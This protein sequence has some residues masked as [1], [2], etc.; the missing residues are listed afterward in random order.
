[1]GD[2]P[3]VSVTS[4]VD[5]WGRFT[6][7]ALTLAR[8]APILVMLRVSRSAPAP[9]PTDW[10]VLGPDQWTWIM[11]SAEWTT[12]GGG[13]PTPRLPAGPK[14]PA[15]SSFRLLDTF[16]S[17]KANR[18]VG[19]PASRSQYQVPLPNRRLLTRQR[20]SAMW[21][22]ALHQRARGPSALPPAMR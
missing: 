17:G 18:H 8:R 21:L 12:D 4:N 19:T 7:T 3:M 14:G 16:E 6:A 13:R 9:L 22:S 20:A 11:R 10:R 1:M 5:T 2:R 15:L